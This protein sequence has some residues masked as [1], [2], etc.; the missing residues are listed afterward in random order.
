MNS[1][2]QIATGTI[3]GNHWDRIQS[4]PAGYIA[5]PSRYPAIAGRIDGGG[6]YRQVTHRVIHRLWVLSDTATSE[7]K[8]EM[9]LSP[10]NKVSGK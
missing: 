9:I 6:S 10:G 8:R 3:P 5:V 1:S 2:H 4:L 7:N